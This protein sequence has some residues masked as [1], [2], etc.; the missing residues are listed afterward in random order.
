MYDPC[1]L[2]VGITPRPTVLAPANQ[3]LESNCGA[4]PHFSKADLAVELPGVGVHVLK[5]NLSVDQHLV[6]GVGEPCLQ[7]A[8]TM[9]NPLGG[10]QFFSKQRELCH[11]T[12]PFPSSAAPIRSRAFRMENLG[13]F[14]SPTI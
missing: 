12:T 3:Q 9:E 14:P 5:H 6:A 13:T 2:S 1:V 7:A 4:R 8:N 10:L 11:A